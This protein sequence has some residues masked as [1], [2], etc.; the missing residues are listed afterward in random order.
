MEP[1]EDV[2]VDRVHVD[3]SANDVAMQVDVEWKRNAMRTE[4]ADPCN[5]SPRWEDDL[6]WGLR[7]RLHRY[8]MAQKTRETRRIHSKQPEPRFS[9]TL[10]PFRSIF[11]PSL[12]EQ[13]G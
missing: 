4:M 7:Q 5:L 2:H 8:M 6:G 11:F 1:N 3:R 9:P 13:T 12:F 10:R